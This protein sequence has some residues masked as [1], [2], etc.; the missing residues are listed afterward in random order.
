MSQMNMYRPRI[1]VTQAELVPQIT[2]RRKEKAEMVGP[3]KE[4]IYDMHHVMLSVKSRRVPGAMT[5]EELFTASAGDSYTIDNERYE[6]E[7]DYVGLLIEEE[8]K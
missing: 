3:W 4:K 5:D 8:K 7:E 1:D 6:T 2:W